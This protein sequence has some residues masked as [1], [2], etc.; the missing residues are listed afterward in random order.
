MARQ[1][2]TEIVGVVENMSY[3][4]CPECGERFFPFGRDGGQVLAEQLD[5]PLLARV[6]MD[7]TWAPTGRE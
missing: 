6:P 7:R 5:V 4:T 3:M 1:T 2:Q